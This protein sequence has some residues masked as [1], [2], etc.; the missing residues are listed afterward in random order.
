M[1][2]IIAIN[3]LMPLISGRNALSILLTVSRT[4]LEFN[5]NSKPELT[6][7]AEAEAVEE[8]TI[9]AEEVITTIKLI[10]SKTWHRPTSQ[11]P[12]KKTHPM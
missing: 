10:T 11:K 8:E 1:M 2:S 6:P 7:E 9:K 3:T 12:S 4:V 5:E